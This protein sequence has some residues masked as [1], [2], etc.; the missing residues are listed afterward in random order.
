LSD[1]SSR[2]DPGARA[3]KIWD[4]PIRAFHW[5]LVASIAG[6]WA[7]A[8]IGDGA[9]MQQHIW[10]GYFT[11]GLILF[12]LA[13]GLIGSR[14]ARF[15]SFLAGPRAFFGY[16]SSLFGKSHVEAPGHNPMGG[17][18]VM[19]LLALVG[20]QV[21]TGLFADD[22][23]VWAGPWAHTVSGALS[24]SMTSWHH[25]IFTAIQIAVV[26][27]VSAIAYYGFVLRNNLVGPMI[28]GR[29]AA[30][31]IG[32]ETAIAGTPW[33]RAA[34]AVALATAV[35][36]AAVQLAPPRPADGYGDW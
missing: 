2:G 17:W 30:D 15:A 25:T 36:T 14:H 32:E 18:M 16:A 33:L 3:R 31:R 20:A 1:A 11:G 19:A 26:L 34:I 5:L 22:D 29:K 4:I 21:V 28:T 13:W 9:Y 6:L 10:L 24:S 12:R 35:M 8:E 27:H 23:I 7:S